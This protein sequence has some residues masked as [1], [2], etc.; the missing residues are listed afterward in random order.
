MGWIGWSGNLLT[1]EYGALVTIG[2]VVTSAEL[3]P[4]PMVEED[5]C[6][7]CKICVATC[8][9][10]Y[11]PKQHEDV[12]QIGGRASHYSHRRSTMRCT[13]SRGGCNNVRKDT[14]RWS[15]WS[16]RTMANMPGPGEPDE[17]FDDR[18][19]A[20]VAAGDPTDIRMQSM[21][22]IGDS[23]ANSW[24]DVQRNIDSSLSVLTCSLCQVVCTPGIDSRRK[25]YRALVASGRVE[26]DD[27]PLR[28]P[29]GRF[30][31]WVNPTLESI[32]AEMVPPVA[33]ESGE[34]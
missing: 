11:M 27:P 16:P 9:T 24:E 18:C 21:V 10:H 31:S 28:H 3:A 15:T 1:R 23:T 12:V 34:D 6:S 13:V 32:M 2:S 4:S 22:Y 7:N 19:D 25:N 14:S 8:P 17:A 33:T 5:W 30:E 29:T 26:E 20:D